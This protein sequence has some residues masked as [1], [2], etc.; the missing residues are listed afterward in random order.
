M[1]AQKPNPDPKP[2][3]TPEAQNADVAATSEVVSAATEKRNKAEELARKREALERELA[4]LNEE[5]KAAG[6][7]NNVVPT[8]LL[9]L[10]DGTRVESAGAVPTHFSTPDGRVQPVDRVYSLEGLTANA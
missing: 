2:Q 5:A 7:A 4:G 3:D 6:L 8:H 9:V 10:A 1:A